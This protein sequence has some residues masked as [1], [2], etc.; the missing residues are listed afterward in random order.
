[1]IDTS[2]AIATILVLSAQPICSA[3]FSIRAIINY[4]ISIV[5]TS[6]FPAV[7]SKTQL[8]SILATRSQLVVL[9]SDATTINVTNTTKQNQAGRLL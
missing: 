5:Y 8:I 7:Y 1:M 9:T 3:S 2:S 6:L 4:K